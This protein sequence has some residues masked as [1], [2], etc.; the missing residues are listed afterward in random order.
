MTEKTL[1][2]SD[3][4]LSKPCEQG[5]E[6]EYISDST[7]KASGVFITVLGGHSEKVKDWV[8]KS[9]NRMR[10][11]DAILTK[12]G[13]DDVRSVEEDEQFSF[14]NAA[15]RIMSWRGITEEC[16]FKNAVLLC[17]INQEIRDQVLGNSEELG[18]FIKS[19]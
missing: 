4:D 19:K 10:Q 13:K 12:K 16:N 6:F 7:G 15:I 1:S 17:S 8:R 18:N 11:R 9:L 2:L 3:L 5:F 14:E